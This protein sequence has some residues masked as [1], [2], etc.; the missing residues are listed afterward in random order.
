[1]KIEGALYLLSYCVEEYIH[2][3]IRV[4]L[5]GNS[6]LGARILKTSLVHGYHYLSLQSSVSHLS[7][8]GHL[9]GTLI[10]SGLQIPSILSQ[11]WVTAEN[12]LALQPQCGYFLIS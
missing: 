6:K 5:S 3:L 4:E 9:S 10:L 2:I 12:C 1:M 8:W 11:Y 7:I